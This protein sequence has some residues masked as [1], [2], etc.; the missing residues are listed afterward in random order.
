[1]IQELLTRH[2]TTVWPVVFLVGSLA[3]YLAILVSVWLRPSSKEGRDHV[4]ALP[5]AA[6]TETESDSEG[7]DA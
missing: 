4:A 7:R 1:M 3:V 6:D 2:G 5:L